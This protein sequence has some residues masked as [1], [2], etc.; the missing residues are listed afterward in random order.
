MSEWSRSPV[1]WRNHDISQEREPD[2]RLWRPFLSES[3]AELDRYVALLGLQPIEDPSNDDVALR[4]NTLR[5]QI[6]PVL[7]ER[8]PGAAVALARY[9]GLAADEDRF[10]DEL[11]QAAVARAIE[12]RGPLHVAGLSS[13][14]PAL[15]RRMVRIWLMGFTGSTPLSAE[16]T[17]AVLALAGSNVGGKRIEVGEG[18]TVRR[19]RGMLIAERLANG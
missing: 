16:R 12:P 2:L 11:A 14:P 3:R 15:R 6:L 8:F 1:P 18:W 13:E 7:E 17:E 19:E 10:L 4:R 5:H 9:A